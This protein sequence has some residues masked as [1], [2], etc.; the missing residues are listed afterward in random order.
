MGIRAGICDSP[1][2]SP[3]PAAVIPHSPAKA[4]LGGSSVKI[5]DCLSGRSATFTAPRDSQSWDTAASPRSVS[6]FRRRRSA[7]T[8]S[9]SRSGETN[10]RFRKD[11][12]AN[13]ASPRTDAA[14]APKVKLEDA[15]KRSITRSEPRFESKRIWP[16]IGAS[17]SGSKGNSAPSA[18]TSCKGPRGSKVQVGT[19]ASRQISLGRP[20]G[21]PNFMRSAGRRFSGLEARCANQGSSFLIARSTSS[22]GG[23]VS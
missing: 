14:P 10:I 21:E 22:N 6:V 11:E 20:R 15:G 13:R 8:Y 5:K 17:L 18:S 19:P 3:S 7:S 2:A 4:W 9:S 1:R 16:T 12:L 23:G